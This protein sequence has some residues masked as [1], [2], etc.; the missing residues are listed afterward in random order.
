MKC[1]KPL[2]T[3]VRSFLLFLFLL[4]VAFSLTLTKEQFEK[5]AQRE[6]KKLY[7][8]AVLEGITLYSQKV[9]LPNLPLVFEIDRNFG[10]FVLKVQDPLN[11][12]TLIAVP[13]KVAFKQ[14]VPVAVRDINPGEVITH[15]NVQFEERVIKTYERSQIAS[16]P[17]GK[18]AKTFI[19][20][21]SVI[22]KRYVGLPTVKAGKQVTVEFVKGALVIKTYGTLLDNGRI[23]QTVRVKKGNKVFLG[24]LKDENTVV[25]E[26]P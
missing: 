10:S 9:E 17:F 13:L 16:N 22:Y 21:G 8:N 7:P 1:S 18:V 11:G 24:R 12:E 5:I 19:P 26:L 23:G 15:G 2:P 20:K 4:K 25:V 14:K 3:S 6:L